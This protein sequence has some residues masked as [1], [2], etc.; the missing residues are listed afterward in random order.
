MHYVYVS[1][2]QSEHT[3][4]VYVKPE[5]KGHPNLILVS[6]LGHFSAMYASSEQDACRMDSTAAVANRYK[7]NGGL[8]S[9]D[10]SLSISKISNLLQLDIK[11]G[12]ER[13]DA[14]AV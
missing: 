7:Q 11:P 5:W 12:S 13:M 2:S 3:N 6:W 10:L 9:K 4:K 14:L 8:H 1:M